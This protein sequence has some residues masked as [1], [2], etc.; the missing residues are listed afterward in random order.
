MEY[1]HDLSELFDDDQ[2]LAY[3]KEVATEDL[4]PRRTSYGAIVPRMTGFLSAISSMLI[5]YVIVRSS[6]GLSTIYHRIM[7]GMSV[8]DI[9]TSVAMGLTTL[10]MPKDDIWTV[11]VPILLP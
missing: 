10:P 4:D 11:R 2:V 3:L 8:F 9:F 6:R 5:M 7:F 1:Y